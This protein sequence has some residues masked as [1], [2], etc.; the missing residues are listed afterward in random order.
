MDLTLASLIENY[1]WSS[2]FSL[3]LGIVVVEKEINCNKSNWNLGKVSV[4]AS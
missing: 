2:F 1:V 4:S 3:N